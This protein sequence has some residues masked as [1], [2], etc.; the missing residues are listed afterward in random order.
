MT[1]NR[2]LRVYGVALDGSA[3]TGGVDTWLD[4]LETDLRAISQRRLTRDQRA[5]LLRLLEDAY[6]NSRRRRLEPKGRAA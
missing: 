5:R 1:D 2:L 6:A 3:E 4:Y